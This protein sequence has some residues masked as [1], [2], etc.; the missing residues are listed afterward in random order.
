MRIAVTIRT[1]LEFEDLEDI[2]EAQNFIDEMSADEILELANREGEAI[3]IDID[4]T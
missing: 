4:E 2:N 1:F 3:N